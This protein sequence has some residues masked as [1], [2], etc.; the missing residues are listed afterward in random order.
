[1]PRKSS[2]AER[3]SL[4]SRYDKLYKEVYNISPT[5]NRNIEQWASS[6]L[7]DSYTLPMCYRMIEYYF[8]NSSRHD[9]SHFVYSADKIYKNII[10]IDKDKEERFQRRIL[11]RRWLS[12]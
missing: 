8:L 5:Y 12:E 1:M 6:D 10:E 2:V 11:A 3:H 4:L 9:W 7:I